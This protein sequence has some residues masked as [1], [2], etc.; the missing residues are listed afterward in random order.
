MGQTFPNGA[1]AGAKY[2]TANSQNGYANSSQGAATVTFPISS[3]KRYYVTAAAV[4]TQL[5]NSRAAYYFEKNGTQTV[6]F[7]VR[8]SMAPAFSVNINGTNLVV[9]SSTSGT[10]YVLVASVIPLDE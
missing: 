3:G 1:A 10:D 7:N 4:S 6:L 9:Y 8:G 5:V 2:P